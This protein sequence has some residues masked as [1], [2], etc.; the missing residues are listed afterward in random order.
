MHRP[1][2]KGEPVEPLIIL[3][4]PTAVGKT[5]L[6]L[7][8]AQAV[9]GEIIS[10]DSMQVYCG[11]DIG[12]AK[13]PLSERKGI[14]HHLIDILDPDEPW[15]VSQFTTLAKEAIQKIRACGHIPIVVGGT[16]FYIQALVKDITFEEE[17]RDGYREQLEATPSDRLAE[18]LAA[19]DP[20]SAASIPVGNRKRMIRAIEYEHY[21]GEPISALNERQAAQPS[22]YNCAYFV[23]TMDR[24]A[25]YERINERVNAMI[26][27]GLVDEVRK[28]LAS[29][30]REDSVAMQ[31][32]GY[33]QM[34][35]Y[36]RGECSLE[37]A[38][39]RIQLETRHF[40]KRQMTWFRREKDVIF[41]DK[42][43]KTEEELLQTM[44]AILREKNIL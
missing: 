13:I 8:L 19:V 37:D 32:L 2:N 43:T 26:R 15:D 42:D 28:L 10:A 7:S 18:M 24:A 16:G 14:R 11:M 30:C 17:P 34:L 33:R 21:H 9:G 25:L 36:L 44:L 29:G 41:L 27:E 39:A 40:A 20:A 31:G 12:T 4:G 22:A 38:T 1:E 3:S 23:L 6:S 35:P 5:E